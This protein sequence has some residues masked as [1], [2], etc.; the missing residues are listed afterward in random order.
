M[1]LVS[2]KGSCEG[3]EVKGIRTTLA[4]CGMA[5]VLA[6]CSTASGQS[7]P[8]GAQGVVA[9]PTRA[10][11][12]DTITLSGKNWRPNSQVTLAFSR[13]GVQ[14]DVATD[15]GKATADSTGQFKFVT[16]VPQAAAPGEWTIGARADGDQNSTTSFTVLEGGTVNIV[17]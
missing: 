6:A 12:G 8:G 16:I 4:V 13:T 17:A 10:R 3:D 5:L 14:D 15:L 2:A 9:I 1:L 7:T 11:R